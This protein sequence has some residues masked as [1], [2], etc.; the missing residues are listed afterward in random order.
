MTPESCFHPPPPPP[1]PLP[2]C[3]FGDVESIRVLSNQGAAIVNLTTIANAA[4]AKE[5]LDGL[6]MGA[7][8]EWTLKVDYLTPT[9]A[10]ERAMDV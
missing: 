6:A 3:Q 10:R 2:Q 8:T 9:E 1:L 5:A 4:A 7:N